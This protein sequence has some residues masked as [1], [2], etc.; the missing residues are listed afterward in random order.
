MPTMFRTPLPASSHGGIRIPPL[1]H[2][3]RSQRRSATRFTLSSGG[4]FSSDAR[5]AGH[6]D[7]LTSI[8][9][10]TACAVF[11]TVTVNTPFETLASIF[12]ASMPSG[13]MKERWNSP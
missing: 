8:F 5:Q 7:A 1:T 11:G 3:V 13:K 9:F 2:S 12:S 4:N 10:A 6:A